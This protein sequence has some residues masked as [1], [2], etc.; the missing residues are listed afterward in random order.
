MKRMK[1]RLMAALLSV[2]IACSWCMPVSAA[3][4]HDHE[5]DHED[6]CAHENQEVTKEATVTC[7]EK[8][9]TAE[10][11][12]KDCG[13]VL[14][15][16][17]SVK[18]LGHNYKI[19]D[20][21]NP[22]KT[23]TNYGSD[24]YTHW[25]ECVNCGEKKSVSAHKYDKK[26]TCEDGATCTTCGQETAHKWGKGTD[27]NNKAT[28]ME[29]GL[30]TYTCSD[31]T[32]G[33]K[34]TEEIAPLGHNYSKYE[35]TAEGHRQI[36][37]ACKATTELVAH[38]YE[39]KPCDQTAKCLDCGYSRKKGQHDFG[40]TEPGTAEGHQQICT[41]CG[42]EE[43]AAHTFAQDESGAVLCTVC[44]Y[45]ELEG[46]HTWNTKGKVTVKATCTEDGVMTYTCKD[47]KC[48]ATKT[49]PIPAGHS[50]KKY[51][52]TAEGHRQIC[53]VCK[54]TT[55][56]A[57]HNYDNKDC[58]KKAKC[59]DCGYQRKA[60]QHEYVLDSSRE[61]TSE[62]HWLVCENCDAE[63]FAAHDFGDVQCLEENVACTDGCGYTVAKVPHIWKE[64]TQVIIPATC[65]EGGLERVICDRCGAEE[66]RETDALGHLPA[67]KYMTDATGHWKKCTRKGCGEKVEFAEHQF[68]GD[69]CKKN[70]PCLICKY[71]SKGHALSDWQ[72]N[73]DS[74]W[75]ECTQ[76]GEKANEAEHNFKGITCKGCGYVKDLTYPITLIGP[77]ET[78]EN[79]EGALV[80]VN[81]EIMVQGATVSNGMAL[82]VPEKDCWTYNGWKFTTGE[83]KKAKNL[84]TYTEV[85]EKLSDALLK[86]IES[87]LVITMDSV[88]VGEY[89][90]DYGEDGDALRCYVCGAMQDIEYPI[91]IIGPNDTWETEFPVENGEVNIQ[92]ATIS[93]GKELHVP[94][95]EYWAYNGWQFRAE[96]RGP[97]YVEGEEYPEAMYRV[98]E[99]LQNWLFDKIE[100][101]FEI[102]MDSAVLGKSYEVKH[103]WF[104]DMGEM[105]GP[106]LCWDRPEDT[107][108]RRLGYLLEFY[109]ETEGNWAVSRQTDT[110]MTECW[111]NQIPELAAGHYTKVSIR[112][113]DYNEGKTIGRAELAIDLTVELEDDDAPM[114]ILIEEP[115]AVNGN[116]KQGYRVWGTGLE[117]ERSYGL[118]FKDDGTKWRFGDIL[119]S[120]PKSG[121]SERRW[122]PD[123]PEELEM[124]LQYVDDF[125][126]EWNVDKFGNETQSV[127]VDM[128]VAG[129][130]TKARAVMDL[131]TFDQVNHALRDGLLNY[132]IPEDLDAKLTRLD[133]AKLMASLYDYP[134]V[135]GSKVK[136]TDCKKLTALEK[137]IIASMEA[138]GKMSSLS[139]K[140]W[141]ID[142]ELT[143]LQ[144]GA[145]IHRYLGGTFGEDWVIETIKGMMKYGIMQDEL[146]WEESVPMERVLEY[147]VDAKNA[148]WRVHDDLRME[149][150]ENGL[151]H[152]FDV[153]PSD[154]DE[155]INRLELASILVA[156]GDYSLWGGEDLELEDCWDMDSRER[157]IIAT[158]MRQGLLKA[159]GNKFQPYAKITRAQLAYTLANILGEI[160]VKYSQ[161][162]TDVGT[163]YWCYDEITS[164]YNL[165]VV[166]GAG[167]YFWPDELASFVD[168][169]QW[170]LNSKK[171]TNVSNIRFEERNGM[172]VLL[173]DAPKLA[174]FADEVRYLVCLNGEVVTSTG[175]TRYNGIAYL[176]PGRYRDVT[177]EV[178]VD[179][180]TLSSV[181][182]DDLWLNINNDWGHSQGETWFEVA[183]GEGHFLTASPGGSSFSVVVFEDDTNGQYYVESKVIEDGYDR[184]GLWFPETVAEWIEN[185]DGIY[186]YREYHD[187]MIGEDG[188]F[189]EINVQ[190]QDW[191]PCVEPL[192]DDYAVTNLRFEEFDGMPILAWDVPEDVDLRNIEYQIWLNGEQVTTTGMTRYLGTSYLKPDTYEGVTVKTGYWE[193][194]ASDDWNFKV[195]ASVTDEDMKLTI[196]KGKAGTANTYFEF[197]EDDGRYHFFVEDNMG[198]S[199][200]SV[201]VYKNDKMQS[202]G[203]DSMEFYGDYSRYGT[204]MDDYISDWIAT[205]EAIY[206][207]REYSKVTY[208]TNGKTCSF[209]ARDQDWRECNVEAE[210]PEVPSGDYYIDVFMEGPQLIATIVAPED[211][212]WGT[213]YSYYFYN[214]ENPRENDGLGCMWADAWQPFNFR[215]GY[216]DCYKVLLWDEEAAWGEGVVLGEGK[217]AKPISSEADCFEISGITL[218]V[219][220]LG[221]N[222]RYN[223]ILNGLDFDNYNYTL[224]GEHAGYFISDESVNIFADDLEGDLTLYATRTTE[225]EECFE[226]ET[227]VG[228]VVP[229]RDEPDYGD[230]YAVTNVHF[231]IRD[232]GAY[233]VWDEP[234]VADVDELEYYILVPEE[235]EWVL[236]GRTTKN[237]AW[238][239]D[240]WSIEA[241]H[242]LTMRNGEEL[243]CVDPGLSI[244]VDYVVDDENPPVITLTGDENQRKEFVIEGLAPNATVNLRFLDASEEEF[245]N[246]LLVTDADGCVSGTIK[247]S[248]SLAVDEIFFEIYQ[249]TGHELS[250]DG[251]VLSYTSTRRGYMLPANG[252]EPEEYTAWYELDEYG[253]LLLRTNLPFPEFENEYYT[254]VE[255]YEDANGEPVEY[256][257]DP[258]WELYGDYIGYDYL[259]I[260]MSSYEPGQVIE[261][262]RVAAVADGVE[263]ASVVLDQA[264]EVTE[265]AGDAVVVEEITV[266]ELDNGRLMYAIALEGGVEE[267]A[268]YA[269]VF[270]GD[271]GNSRVAYLFEMDGMLATVR[272]PDHFVGSGKFYVVKSTA[273]LN[274]DGNGTLTYTPQTAGYDYDPN[275][276]EDDP[277]EGCTA[278]WAYHPYY[279]TTPFLYWDTP[280][281]YK[282]SD[283][284][285]LYLSADGGENWKK[286]ISSKPAAELDRCS[287]L[288]LTEYANEYNMV[289]FEYRTGDQVDGFYTADI[290]LSVTKKAGA[291]TPD[292]VTAELMD[293]TYTVTYTGMTPGALYKISYRNGETN[294][295]SYY[296]FYFSAD[297]N[298][299][300]VVDSVP[301]DHLWY[302]MM[303]YSNVSVSDSYCQ[304]TEA[305]GASGNIL[306]GGE[307]PEDPELTVAVPT[308]MGLQANSL[309]LVWTK[310]SAEEQ[311]LIQNMTWN[312]TI[313]NGETVIQKTRNVSPMAMSSGLFGSD[314]WMMV[315]TNQVHIEITSNPTA[316]AAAEGY[317]AGTTSFDATVVYQEETATH[318]TANI[319]GTFL[320]GEEERQKVLTVTGL[321]A[322]QPYVIEVQVGEAGTSN[323]RTAT[324]D[325]NGTLVSRWYTDY[326]FTQF[327][328]KEWEVTGDSTSATVICRPYDGVYTLN[329]EEGG[330]EP[331]TTDKTA[332]GVTMEQRGMYLHVVIDTPEN[333]DGVGGYGVILYDSA[334]RANRWIH[335][336]CDVAN[337]DA[338]IRVDSFNLDFHYDMIAVET[339]DANN[340]V[341]ANW[342]APLNVSMAEEKLDYAVEYALGANSAKI[343]ASEPV[344]G[345]VGHFVATSTSGANEVEVSRGYRNVEGENSWNVS[346]EGDPAAY[347]LLNNNSK[348]YLKLWGWNPSIWQNDDGIWNVNFTVL[349]GDYVCVETVEAETVPAVTDIW[350]QMRGNNGLDVYWTPGEGAEQYNNLNYLLELS[351]D[352]GKTWYEATNTSQTFKF[353]DHEIE[354]PAGTYDKI[355]VTSK[356]W[357]NSMA[358]GVYV[359]DCDLTITDM[360]KDQIPMTALATGAFRDYGHDNVDYEYIISV[361]GLEK[362]T[363]YILGHRQEYRSGSSSFYTDR[364]G[365]AAE[366]EYLETLDGTEF[367][368]WKC[369][370]VTA[371]GTSAALTRTIYGD[372]DEPMVLTMT[373][374]P[375]LVQNIEFTDDFHL[376]LYPNDPNGEFI[377]YVVSLS[378]DDG[379]TWKELGQLY[380]GGGENFNAGYLSSDLLDDDQNQV[381]Y[382]KL[383]VTASSDAYTASNPEYCVWDCDITI[384]RS[385]LTGLKPTFEYV[386]GRT[387]VTITNL[388]DGVKGGMFRY[389]QNPKGGG[390]SGSGANVNEGVMT[391]RASR[392]LVNDGYSY[393][394]TVYGDIVADGLNLSATYYASDWELCV[395]SPEEEPCEHTYS[396][397]SDTDCDLCGEGRVV[398]YPLLIVGPNGEM[399]D[400]I[401]VENGEAMVQGA[402]MSN[403]VPLYVPVKDNWIYN[404]WQFTAVEQDGEVL[405]LGIHTEMSEK[406]NAA[407]L[408]SIDCDRT[409][410]MDS[411]IVG[412]EVEEV[413]PYAVT[414]V[415]FEEDYPGGSLVW[416][417]PENAED[418]RYFVEILQ[419]GEVVTGFAD[420]EFDGEITE[421]PMTLWLGGEYTFRITTCTMD[422]ESEEIL[423]TFAVVEP[424]LTL[425]VNENVEDEPLDLVVTDWNEDGFW[426]HLSDMYT[427]GW[428][429]VYFFYDNSC[430]TAYMFKGIEGER[431]VDFIEWVNGDMDLDKYAIDCE[432]M[433]DYA[434]SDDGQTM[435]YTCTKLGDI[436]QIEVLDLVVDE[437]EVQKVIYSLQDDYPEGMFWTNESNSY[438]WDGG[439]YGTGYGCAAFTFLLSDEAFGLL[440][441]KQIKNG[442]FEFEDVR[443]GD[444]LRVDDDTHS[445]IVIDRD[446]NGVT[447][448]EGN[449]NSSIHWGRKFTVKEV[450]A[451]DY[452]LTRY[453]D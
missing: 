106:V 226:Q 357:D 131:D 168:V 188:E 189:C 322:N 358:D 99:D 236:D 27:K 354:L 282:N 82:H 142:E 59:E 375:D 439:I 344:T 359:A 438:M 16:Q 363:Q 47:K 251:K 452:I 34:A 121:E 326:A 207:Y 206:Y 158:A 190:D 213:E 293:G 413:N 163:K 176:E 162:L 215:P 387:N 130:W 319:A 161:K 150:E 10:I 316:A 309:T 393:R 171:V 297:E 38:D 263:V 222:N 43:T 12:C 296:E 95:K 210:E 200:F 8:G 327:T 143:K 417:N 288:I 437:D 295:S 355:R 7:T 110:D 89:D 290:G 170:A 286:M 22:K 237:E 394:L 165:G 154:M 403:G 281:A 219:G 135:D 345:N 252:E 19:P 208:G 61:V 374:N 224:E 227:S 392:D 444:I 336:S 268:S 348:A 90:H 318:D 302:E 193:Q 28:C 74:H 187:L 212:E 184:Y 333:I 243:D 15:E 114:L 421:V 311:A 407:L 396:S 277:T 155:P 75:K 216:Y 118:M 381:Y 449:Y 24:E 214:S 178:E 285:Y 103:I 337:H 33:E 14:Q 65:T 430:F 18:K 37:S 126:I 169:F 145:L 100:N 365:K 260:L 228:Y 370:D 119:W 179:G 446:D 304:L 122:F 233:L 429:C 101:G 83:G 405:D 128:V 42:K 320:D 173:W 91:T 287:A 338:W 343:I 412:E 48:K 289:K 160:D 349:N 20:P 443:I 265:P 174:A 55:E 254:L 367:L 364:E 301:Q 312:Y 30:M 197:L 300:L 428:N 447:V 146:D 112:T 234:N 339:L 186:F 259:N 120:G 58:D 239:V 255:L 329:A 399:N 377:N 307:E 266:T 35:K 323:E 284:V 116:G 235:D 108:D 299:V 23:V 432:A 328:V 434:I 98:T 253:R 324:T 223:C 66:E 36:C 127:H 85:T 111:V 419:D 360:Q 49:E 245:S 415:R 270:R 440:P 129:G 141:G 310:P 356:T 305:P 256:D 217:L 123:D 314:R 325:A 436:S 247:R 442:N 450:E 182:D 167:S 315:G 313:T 424:D 94:E 175:G 9:L 60:G 64:K 125:E 240:V 29:P 400:S 31:K 317:V 397:A 294:P 453:P 401:I 267:T 283:T 427:V 52:K 262:I 153:D 198:G 398:T 369:S 448:A 303:E 40:A 383:K 45:A 306:E 17:K 201:C 164:L 63:T 218:T 231:E 181:K 152:H 340:K 117:P 53:S 279:K 105:E 97:G 335:R 411:A 388:P 425:A 115:G 244:D 172:P 385:A 241:V 76:C 331:D 195:L 291:N 199:G 423:E 104:K 380:D 352:G 242:I 402:T 138:Y 350:F 373:E 342:E 272:D 32:C 51:E 229:V 276:G 84:G 147:L 431:S 133:A 414:N 238:V 422:Y 192:D 389:T 13:E 269:L 177:I 139:T 21:E 261:K 408:W 230:D 249:M 70:N 382:N 390:W 379:Q 203:V 435:S 54:E 39:D 264:L 79:H 92:G 191:T 204:G 156:L 409:I 109:N 148:Q 445:V 406:L 41:L 232:G 353:I 50:Y 271:A 194:R 102:T 366:S 88:A 395:S 159:N 433:T 368:V 157:D 3:E 149:A 418:M 386:D 341:I 44:N 441:A 292:K 4:T 71:K 221:Q 378:A 246:N 73:E 96:K 202:Y 134:L 351:S 196:T 68:E 384:T 225:T 62:G 166:T 274:E 298:G 5:H 185:G 308:N 140:V 280:A 80:V 124:L 46:E 209:T 151:L 332:K 77:N 362:N 258:D 6:T 257:M 144:V 451:A 416:N 87:E 404:G 11:V 278:Y 347:D 67:T 273:A 220:E 211:A 2:A 78:W 346:L 136:Y 361:A 420:G 57:A 372:W 113:L 376:Y 410:T 321:K 330:E 25:Q 56:L 69:P 371:N 107:E 72:W 183:N 86:A 26:D 180:K 205:G 93:N 137:S 250:D 334:D 391:A 1:Q 81:G 132:M 426:Y 248:E 275:S